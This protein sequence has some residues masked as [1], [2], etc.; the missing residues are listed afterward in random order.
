MLQVALKAHSTDVVIRTYLMVAER[1]DVVQ[2]CAVGVAGVQ[3][4]PAKG[5]D[6]DA[7]PQV[8]LHLPHLP[9]M[10]LLT[11]SLT[12][13]RPHSRGPVFLQEEKGKFPSR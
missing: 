9:G 2:V 4:V 6:S 7:S 5:V 13:F 12:P 1:G 10:I 8:H 11:A 3:S